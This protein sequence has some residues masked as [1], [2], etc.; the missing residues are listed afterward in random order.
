M[1]PVESINIFHSAE[2]LSM[3]KLP[4]NDFLYCVVLIAIHILIVIDTGFKCVDV[5]LS[6]H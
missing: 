4:R 2:H 5:T 1:V 3:V 6:L